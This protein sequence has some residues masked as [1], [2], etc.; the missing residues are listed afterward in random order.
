MLGLA[1][2]VPQVPS[3]V[4]VDGRI[5]EVRV[6]EVVEAH[7]ERLL[8]RDLEV[9]VK[10]D[11]VGPSATMS[12]GARPDVRPAAVA[13]V[14]A[15]TPTPGAPPIQAWRRQEEDPVKVLVEVPLTFR[16][17]TGGGDLARAPVQVGLLGLQRQGRMRE[18]L[19]TD[20]RMAGPAH[21]VAT[22]V[23]VTPVPTLSPGLGQRR[24]V[25][26]TTPRPRRLTEEASITGIVGRR[27]RRPQAVVARPPTHPSKHDAP[28]RVTT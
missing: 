1:V 5:R 7:V 28:L 10:A 11:G 26:G 14:S 18:G 4:D 25:A 6:V 16:G 27:G 2:G 3:I 23:D 21:V 20:Q 9:K 8:R 13:H 19:E 12:P 24:V 15:A 22:C 17:A